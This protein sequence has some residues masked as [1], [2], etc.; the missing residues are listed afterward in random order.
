MRAMTAVL[1]L[2][3]AQTP[4]AGVEQM[5]LL[6]HRRTADA[7]ARVGPDGGRADLP[8]PDYAI[9]RPWPW[10]L[11]AGPGIRR[12]IARRKFDAVHCW[13]ADL[14]DPAIAVAPAVCVSVMAPPG[15]K[16]I[17][18]LRSAAND[19]AHVLSTSRTMADRLIARGLPACR[20]TVATPAAEPLDGDEATRQAARRHLGLPP[21]HHVVLA[22]AQCDDDWGPCWAIWAT[23][24]LL[25]ILP[26]FHLVIPGVAPAVQRAQRF[27]HG[28]KIADC[29]CFPG[30]SGESSAWAAAD[31]ALLY[32][33]RGFGL[34]GA[35]KA[36]A[37]SLPII[38][39]GAGELG[40]M[41]VDG[42]TAVLAGPAAP[43]LLA[44]AIW[45]L[46]HQ[47]ELAESLV[48]QAK[49]SLAH[50]LDVPAA[51]EAMEALYRRL[52]ADVA[53]GQAGQALGARA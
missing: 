23:G 10:M 2:F 42:Q 27:A 28:T 8:E 35:A 26:G 41:L 46:H 34:S 29:I 37:A 9:R 44:Q 32:D 36:T 25:H 45:K 20:V 18:L 52:A 21:R 38:A 17:S 31:T 33:R 22:P 1:H 12:L 50:L 47:P 6:R 53:P 4:P 19:G 24:I 40:D 51:V 16:Q 3:D 39:T 11:T 14:A 7:L 48:V 30:R 13:S 43:R 15:K 5:L 49:A